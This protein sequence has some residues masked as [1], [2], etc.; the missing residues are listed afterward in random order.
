MSKPSSLVRLKHLF[1]VFGSPV[2][3]EFALS[4]A[5]AE[6]PEFAYSVPNQRCLRTLLRRLCAFGCCPRTAAYQ[7][8]SGVF[9]RFPQ[10]SQ[11][12]HLFELGC[13]HSI[14]FR[15]QP[16]FSTVALSLLT[17]SAKHGSESPLYQF[18]K[19]PTARRKEGR[20][21]S[22]LAGTQILC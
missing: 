4:R 11:V 2:S 22:S 14:R 5:L 18:W 10:T 12:L 1:R 16:F 3:A 13:N 9:V 7:S 15:P 20:T 21:R 17:P 19:A 6:I 8:S